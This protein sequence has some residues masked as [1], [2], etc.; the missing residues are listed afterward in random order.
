MKVYCQACKIYT[1]HTT[2]RYGD[3]GNRD[4]ISGGKT[5]YRTVKCDV[6]GWEHTAD[7]EPDRR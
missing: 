6:C 1:E 2:V 3:N 5:D 4:L 7:F